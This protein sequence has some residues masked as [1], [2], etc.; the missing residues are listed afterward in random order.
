MI[1][2]LSNPLDMQQVK[3]KLDHFI[4][5]CKVVELTEK[6]KNRTLSQNAY[7]HLLLTWYSFETGM[8]S[9]YV[10]QYIFKVYINPDVF[11]TTTHSKK[12]GEEYEY[13]RSTADLNTAELTLC[14][15]RF[16]NHS[17]QELGIYLPEPNDLASLREMERTL[18]QNKEYL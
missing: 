8:E 3:I 2:D 11:K 1:Y 4:N 12:T 15:D 6:R 13:I 18:S 14:I 9:E 5:K 16:R 7:L 10:K 17:S